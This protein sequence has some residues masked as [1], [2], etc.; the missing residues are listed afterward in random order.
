MFPGFLGMLKQ[1]LWGCSDLVWVWSAIHTHGL[2]FHVSLFIPSLVCLFLKRGAD[3]NARDKNNKDPITIAVDNANADIVTLWVFESRETLKWHVKPYKTTFLTSPLSFRL[4]IAK[5]NK[6]MR[7]MD[8]AFGQSGHSG[9]QGSGGVQGGTGGGLA[10]T[11]K[12]LQAIKNHIS[13]WALGG[14]NV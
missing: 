9:G 6:E 12:S 3:Y 5:M 14:Q 10:H 11:R 1:G 13:G 8:G 2:T 7:E 4:R